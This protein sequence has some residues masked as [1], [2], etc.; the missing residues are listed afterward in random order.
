[1]HHFF[2]ANTPISSKLTAISSYVITCLIFV[3]FAKVEFATVLF[4]KRHVTKNKKEAKRKEEEEKEREEEEK[5]K[6]TDKSIGSKENNWNVDEGD[7]EKENNKGRGMK[8]FSLTAF[9]KD[10]DV[11]CYR[12]DQISFL[13]FFVAFVIYNI[14]FLVAYG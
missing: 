2:K 1:M 10:V 9:V 14:A 8:L 6:E 3:F 5:E 4:L 13:V 7:E 12:M 11:F